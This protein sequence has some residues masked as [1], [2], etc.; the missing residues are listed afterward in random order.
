MSLKSQMV[1]LRSN[2]F[3][4]PASMSAYPM[5]V[6]TGGVKDVCCKQVPEFV[7][8]RRRNLCIAAILFAGTGLYGDLPDVASLGPCTSEGMFASNRKDQ[9]MRYADRYAAVDN[10]GSVSSRFYNDAPVW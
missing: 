2:G 10:A 5:S 6:H 9:W 1:A 4:D 7:V 8:P 3:Y